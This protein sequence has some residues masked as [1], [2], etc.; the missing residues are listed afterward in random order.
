MNLQS[1]PFTAMNAGAPPPRHPMG[2][3]LP[4]RKL[5]SSIYLPDR[6][7]RLK[8][9]N[10]WPYSQ[11]IPGEFPGIFTLTS[12]ETNDFSAGVPTY[13]CLTGFSVFLYPYP[14]AN[15]N[16]TPQIT[17]ELYHPETNQA[18]INPNSPPMLVNLLGGNG[19]N[20]FFFK[21]F[22][23]MDP[24][25]TLLAR[26]SNLGTLTQQGQIVANGFYPVLFGVKQQPAASGPPPGVPF[27]ELHS[28]T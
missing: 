20:P 21:E 8:I 10:W 2:L 12:Q 6:W 26:L 4:R 13:F 3:F 25:D 9:K 18:L 1:N 23:F 14:G 22:F 11:T 5:I 7:Q 27:F 17:I 16:Q 19:K 28:G 24:G 15:I